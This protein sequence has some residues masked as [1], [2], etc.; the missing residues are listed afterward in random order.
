MPFVPA[1]NTARIS[2]NWQDNSGNT[3]VNVIH[4]RNLLG[5]ANAGFMSDMFDSIETWMTGVHDTIVS[6]AWYLRDLEA[7]SLNEED[8]A[9]LS[10]F[11][12]LQGAKASTPMPAQNTVAVSLRSGFAGRSRRGRIYFVGLTEEDTIGDQIVPALTTGL[13]NSYNTLRSNLLAN[14]GE[15]VVASFVSDGAPR[16][17]ALLTPITEIVLVND[18]IDHQLRRN[19]Q[20]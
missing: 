17:T 15:W 3:A 18:Y 1:L 14:D 16:A 8:G 13:I 2:L 11:V 4:V 5:T 6:T 12:N 10:R 19:P 7:I 20:R 9:V